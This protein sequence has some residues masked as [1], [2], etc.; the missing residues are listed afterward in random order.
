MTP[1]TASESSV[2]S[3]RTKMWVTRVRW[4]PAITMKCRWEA[5][6]GDR[7]T[8]SSIAP[9]GPSWGD[10]VGVGVIAQKRYSPAGPVNR[11]ARPA[12]RPSPYWTS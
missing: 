3:P 5:R 8:A 6:M 1:K 2:S 12:V 7:P 9:T 10:G 4:P 11:W